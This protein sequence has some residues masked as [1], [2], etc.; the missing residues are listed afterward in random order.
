MEILFRRGVLQIPFAY[1]NDAN[2]I[3]IVKIEFH[4]ILK[5]FSA[6]F[7]GNRTNAIIVHLLCFDMNVA[8][9]LPNALGGTNNKAH[10]GRSR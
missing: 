4:S 9:H 1:K 5:A 7:P 3:F 8:R 2:I 10:T 6:D